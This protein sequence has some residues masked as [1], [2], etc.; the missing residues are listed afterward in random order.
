MTDYDN[1]YHYYAVLDESRDTAFVAIYIEWPDGDTK[2]IG[3]MQMHIDEW[4]LLKGMLENGA[5]LYR[6][7]EATIDIAESKNG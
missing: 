2:D 7:G 6:D 1:I 4:K 3:F 5:S